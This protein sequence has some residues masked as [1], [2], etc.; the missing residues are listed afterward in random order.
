MDS[1]AAWMHAEWTLA[2]RMSLTT[3][4]RY[5][6][7]DIRLPATSDLEPV[8]LTPSDFTGDLSLL[9]AL[10]DDLH[11]VANAG[12]G[13][14]PP[15]IFDLATLGPRP[16]NRFNVPNPD[17]GPESVWSYD[18]GV[19]FR[20]GDLQYELFA[21]YLDYQDKITS[22]LTGETTPGGRAV[23]R[24]ENRNSLRVHGLEAGLRWTASDRLEVFGTLNYTRGVERDADG[25]T[26]PGDRI[27]PLNGQLGLTW[28]PADAW[29]LK[30]WCL[31]ATRQD[32]LSA[33]DAEDPRINPEGTPGWGTLNLLASRQAGEHWQVGLKLENLGDVS[34]RE[35]GSGVDAP[36]RNIGI[37]ADASW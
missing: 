24:S 13:F 16:G 34:Y 19:K 23:V 7:F 10:S 22:V 14:R 25:Q 35:H 30:A 15:N 17:L 11:L 18:A 26:T 36:G 9:Y 27:P 29:E 31:F 8:E 33:R 21:F 5:S 12:R 4:L 32:R 1:A 3:G 37:F 2:E 6:A 28:Q 20:S